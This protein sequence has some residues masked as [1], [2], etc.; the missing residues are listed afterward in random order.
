[1]KKI[2]LPRVIVLLIDDFCDNIIQSRFKSEFDVYS[3]RNWLFIRSKMFGHGLRSRQSFR[4]FD[5]MSELQAPSGKR[6]GKSKIYFYLYY[7]CQCLSRQ[8]CR[9]TESDRK[10]NYVYTIRTIIDCQMHDC[11]SK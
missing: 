6:P 11:S 1:M 8:K 7:L 5:N 3:V 10:H 9:E 4:R 2:S